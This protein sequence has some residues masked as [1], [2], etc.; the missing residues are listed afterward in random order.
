[1]KY[2]IIRTDGP[3]LARYAAPVGQDKSYV[4]DIAKARTFEGPRGRAAGVLR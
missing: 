1:M 4:R 3:R 2:V